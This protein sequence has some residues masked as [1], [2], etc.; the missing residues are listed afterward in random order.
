MRDVRGDLPEFQREFQ[1]RGRTCRVRV[2]AARVRDSDGL[3]IGVYPSEREELV[4]SAL[5]YLACQQAQGFYTE[6][7]NAPQP[8]SGVT[9][10]IHQI[11][12]LLRERGRWLRH[13]DIV[14]ALEVMRYC[15]ITIETGDRRRD[16]GSPIISGVR[17]MAVDAGD[18]VDS[19]GAVWNVVFNR[20]VTGAI[21]ERAYRQ[22]DF[23]QMVRCK[24]PLT[25][26]LYLALVHRWRNASMTHPMQMSLRDVQRDSG[27]LDYGRFRQA[28][29]KLAKSFEELKE[30]GVLRDVEVEAELGPRQKIMD[31]SYVLR[32]T[33]TFVTKVVKANQR[34][35]KLPTNGR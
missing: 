7:S 30:M 6:R 15:S 3:G 26:W 13:E 17:R 27:F 5:R 16:Y 9:F 2:R 22:F 4:E 33:K 24:A 28:A 32:P 31:V 21:E 14:Q 35:A 12:M 11:R 8:V 29:E 1:Y 25:R 23:D 19:E 18:D 34:S 20:L 10:T